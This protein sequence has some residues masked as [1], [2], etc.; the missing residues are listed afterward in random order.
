MR[1]K[2]VES[3]TLSGGRVGRGRVSRSILGQRGAKCKVTKRKTTKS[4]VGS[5]TRDTV[6]R[7]EERVD[8]IVDKLKRHCDRHWF[9]EGAVIT[10]A[11]GYVVNLVLTHVKF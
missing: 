2:P 5:S 1:R 8:W 10:A 3:K 7:L 4:K 6:I 11:L 9:V